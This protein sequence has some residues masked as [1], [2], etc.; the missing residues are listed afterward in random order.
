[1]LNSIVE[2]KKAVIAKDKQQESLEQ[3]Q[4]QLTKGDFSLSKA[5]KEKEWFLIAV[6]KLASPS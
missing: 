2:K 1:M 3:L 4:Q 5:L 6:G